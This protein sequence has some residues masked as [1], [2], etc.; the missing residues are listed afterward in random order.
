MNIKLSGINVLWYPTVWVWWAIFG[1]F[2]PA[3]WEFVWKITDTAAPALLKIAIV[4]IVLLLSL[5]LYLALTILACA[6]ALALTVITAVVW[7]GAA[8]LNGV[9][10]FTSWACVGKDCLIPFR[11]LPV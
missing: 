1:W 4:G 3:Y 9:F 2:T 5:V 6:V 7:F 10:H 8:L 11:K